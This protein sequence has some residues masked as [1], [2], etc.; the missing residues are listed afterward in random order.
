MWTRVNLPQLVA[1]STYVQKSGALH[2]RFVYQDISVKKVLTRICLKCLRL[3][4]V[5]SF[6]AGDYDST[7]HSQK[8]A[9]LDNAY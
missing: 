3:L 2:I 6:T 7:R 8:Q 4:D 5:D 1:E 9:V